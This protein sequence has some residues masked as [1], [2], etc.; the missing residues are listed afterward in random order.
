MFLLTEFFFF[1]SI[2]N[3]SPFSPPVN[4]TYTADDNVDEDEEDMVSI[5]GTN[6]PSTSKS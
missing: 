5:S 4:E 2:S 6:A 1:R 3:V